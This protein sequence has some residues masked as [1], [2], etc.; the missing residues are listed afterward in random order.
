MTLKPILLALGLTALGTSAK[1]QESLVGATDRLS[2]TL[3]RTSKAPGLAVVLVRNDSVLFARGYGR[4]SANASDH[5]DEK[6]LFNAGGLTKGFTAAVLAMLVDEGKLKWDDPVRTHLPAFRLS[7]AWV[8]EHVTVRDLV[9]M[10]IGM[11]RAD[12]ILKPGRSPEDVLVRAAALPVS[13]FRSSYGVSSNFA[14]FVAGQLAAAVAHQSWSD[15]V[16]ERLLVPLGMTASTLQISRVLSSSNLARPHF[17]RGDSLVLAEL[18]SD[19]V[20]PGAAGLYANALDVGA[21]LRL[22]LGHGRFEGRQLISEA[23]MREMHSPLVVSSVGNFRG[24]FNRYAS[25]IG[26]GLGWHISDYRGHTVIENGGVFD[27]T[28]YILLLPEENMGFAILTNL[29]PALPVW[30]PIQEMKF[31]LLDLVIGP[32]ARPIRKGQ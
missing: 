26:F 28:Q 8:S 17:M 11:P 3:L 29:G 14:Y 31:A 9:L 15:L 18:N 21:W 19:N 25:V 16:S 10:R 5:V 22:Q 6:T 12:T 7:D 13:D 1:A 24:F 23:S 20:M 4:R 27:G 32:T 30:N 2:N